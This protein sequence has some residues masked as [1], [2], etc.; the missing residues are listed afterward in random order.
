MSNLL[1]EPV[2]I[3]QDTREYNR[4][5][6]ELSDRAKMVY[7]PLIDQYHTLNISTL[8]TEDLDVFF[9]NPKVFFVSIL[10]K[11][12]PLTI[13]TIKLQPEKVYD[14][15][16]STTGLDAFVEKLINYKIEAQHKGFKSEYLGNLK[17]YEIVDNK[18]KISE[19]YNDEIVE[20]TNYYA[21]TENQLKAFNIINEVISKLGEFNSIWKDIPV[22]LN[23]EDNYL[24][25][26]APH[27]PTSEKISF[28]IP[29]LLRKSK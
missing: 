12:E 19:V 3:G 16:E 25:N 11:D 18:L 4:I 9:N 10:T 6:S 28:N 26:I 8:T 7:Q 1:E 15:M 27:A 5:I 24:I 20:M 29:E 17:H 2:K 22:L 21:T 13:G 14:F 23:D